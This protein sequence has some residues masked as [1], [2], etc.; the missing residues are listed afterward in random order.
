MRD[1]NIIKLLGEFWIDWS[2]AGYQILIEGVSF[3]PERANY[4]NLKLSGLGRTTQD[5]V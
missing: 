5:R 3:F 4:A 2:Q 1:V